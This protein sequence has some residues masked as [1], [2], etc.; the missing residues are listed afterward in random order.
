MSCGVRKKA[1][2]PRVAI[3]RTLL[4]L[5]TS[6]VLLALAT[7]C[8]EGPTIDI[9]LIHSPAIVPADHFESL[10]VRFTDEL[11]GVIHEGSISGAALTDTAGL[12]EAERL[13]EGNTYMVTIEAEAPTCRHARAVGLSRPFIH[14]AG[15]YS[16]PIQVGCADAFAPPP[17]GLNMACLTP[18][19]VVDGAGSAVVVGGATETNAL[20]DYY[21]L[22]DFI[23]MIERYD[24]STGQFTPSGSLVV[25]RAAPSVISLPSGEVAV[26]GGFESPPT[27][28]SGAI[29]V[30]AGQGAIAAGNL[31]HRRC[32]TAAAL[33]D[34]AGAVVVVGGAWD[35]LEDRSADVE[36][37]DATMRSVLHSSVRGLVFRYFPAVVALSDGLS[38]LMIG[39]TFNEFGH[40]PAVEL[41]RLGGECEVSPCVEEVDTSEVPDAGWSEMAA[42][43]VPCEAGGGAV[44]VTGGYSEG[45][46]TGRT[47]DRVWCY[48]DEPGETGSLRAVGR[49]PEVDLL[50]ASRR[51][52]AMVTVRRQGGGSRLLVIGGALT[53]DDHIYEPATNA[54]LMTV[55]GCRCSEVDPADADIV[56]LH[57]NGYLDYPAVAQLHDGSVLVTGASAL[58]SVEG[59]LYL[60]TGD[61]A[62][63]IPELE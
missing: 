33:L 39:G 36:V 16:V 55:D 22:D 62:L 7:G 23:G 52:H 38:A 24:P 28:C 17:S 29:E 61:V 54:V 26:I 42:S 2:L 8:K 15:D 25:P 48:R 9:R 49:L 60:P 32:G 31:V 11:G 27:I 51:S 4:W 46:T 21:Q 5:T 3:D 35:V 18:G 63:F 56:P 57:F 44:Y 12:L 43:Y 1:I 6:G 58:E 41:L 34:E 19:L 37:H 47:L 53:D 50:P 40:R 10:T 45:E 30:F 14:E 59:S 13:V 20:S